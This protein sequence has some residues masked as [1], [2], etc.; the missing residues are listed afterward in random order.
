MHLDGVVVRRRIPGSSTRA[1]CATLVAGC[2]CVHAGVAR[3]DIAGRWRIERSSGA[4]VF[5][6][7]SQE[8]EQVS[9]RIDDHRFTGTLTSSVLQATDFTTVNRG[10]LVAVVS[11]DESALRG[12]MGFLDGFPFAS[13][14]VGQRCQC[15][16]GNS[17]N[18]DGCDASC[19]IEECFTCATP[20]SCAPAAEGTPCDDGTVCTAGETCGA[21]RCGGGQAVSPCVDL[22]GTWRWQSRLTDPIELVTEHAARF[23]QTGNFLEILALPSLGAAYAGAIDPAT[24]AFA[25]QA[26]PGDSIGLMCGTT[27]HAGM[28]GHAGA[29]ALSGALTVIG[30]PPPS[31]ASFTADLTGRR[32]GAPHEPCIDCP[33][34]C[35]EDFT[36]SVD[37]LV[38][39]INVALDH[40]S[41]L[42]CANGDTNIDGV[43]DVGDLVSAVRSLL[44]GCE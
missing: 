15:F 3:A 40:Q 34:D 20:S 17:E 43:I 9:F 39:T 11:P 16:D 35:N 31:C 2:L 14:L 22:S 36:V 21:G 32:C 5:V 10:M 23:V 4:T 44:D 29:A 19:R 30:G 25:L 33:G 28:R 27:I 38:V 18:G 12:V 13:Q 6:D 8:G 24:G 26:L 42:A 7:V 41:L 37:E 1:I